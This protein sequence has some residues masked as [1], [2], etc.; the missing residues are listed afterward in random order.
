MASSL[1]LF[2]SSVGFGVASGS[3]PVS[4]DV[5]YLKSIAY[6]SNWS[7]S[8][9]L[10]TSKSGLVA[11]A[12]I[13]PVFGFIIIP[14]APSLSLFSVTASSR[15]FSRK[16]CIVSS[17]V[18]TTSSPFWEL[19]KYS[20]CW[21]LSVVPFAD[22]LVSILPLRPIS[23]SSKVSSIPCKPLLSYPVNPKICGATLNG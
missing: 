18:S 11:I 20:F 23:S 22:W 17:I 19:F 7:I 21:S 16:C 14:A 9:G 10:F 15:C 6:F 8:Y 2:G 12:S 1:K 3:S 4:S 5:S 13:S